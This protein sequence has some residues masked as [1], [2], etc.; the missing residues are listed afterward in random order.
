M[1]VGD[2]LLFITTAEQEP[3]LQQLVGSRARLNDVGIER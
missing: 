3:Q 2:E 1:E